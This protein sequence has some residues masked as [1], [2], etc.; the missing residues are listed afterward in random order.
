M[1]NIHRSEYTT[2]YRVTV[3]VLWAVHCIL[4]LF[5]LLQT[6]QP[7]SW[8]I[9]A[10]KW[11]DDWRLGFLLL[12]YAAVGSLLMTSLV[13]WLDKGDIARELPLR[14]LVISRESAY[15]RFAYKLGLGV[16]G[17]CLTISLLT[18]WNQWQVGVIWKKRFTYEEW[19]EL[20][21]GKGQS[22]TGYESYLQS[23][24]REPSDNLLST[25]FSSF[26]IAFTFSKVLV[27]FRQGYLQARPLL[28][29]NDVS[30]YWATGPE[31]S[32]AK[33]RD[34]ETLKLKG[35]LFSGSL[36][37]EIKEGSKVLRRFLHVKDFRENELVE[38]LHSLQMELP[39]KVWQID[40]AAWKA[41][42][43]KRQG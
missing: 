19:L 32:E 9:I 3:N 23:V 21:P 10:E 28:A 24:P 5:E 33:L 2:L 36:I 18:S 12:S 41:I 1:I 25:I 37:F 26:L 7:Q 31:V 43:E 4:F 16:L 20:Q 38:W 8:T 13:L 14:K 6:F 34:L 17:L 22:V 35:D 40:E 15:G 42:T 27:K 11:P 30:L 39:G 29:F